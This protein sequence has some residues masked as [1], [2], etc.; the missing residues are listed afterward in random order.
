MIEC[1]TNHLSNVIVT[2][3]TTFISYIG[4]QI[5]KTYQEK[6]QEETKRKIVTSGVKAT[7]QVYQNLKGNEKLQKAKETILPILKQKGIK[8]V[9]QEI[10]VL[11]EEACHE[12]KQNS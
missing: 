5:K 3:L 9:D 6:I 4:V 12:L 11:I 1:I 10:D 7:E 8:L 2:I